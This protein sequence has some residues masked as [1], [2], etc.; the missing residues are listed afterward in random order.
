MA[1]LTAA[2][3]LQTMFPREGYILPMN[4]ADATY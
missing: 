2:R 1:A 3:Q 4:A